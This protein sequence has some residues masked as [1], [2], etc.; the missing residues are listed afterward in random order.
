MVKK[1]TCYDN[2]RLHY[3]YAYLIYSDF[4]VP[5]KNTSTKKALHTQKKS[6]I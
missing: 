1:N 6:D 4:T 2:T 5:K 3:V